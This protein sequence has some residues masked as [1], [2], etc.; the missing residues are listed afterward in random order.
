M[1]FDLK[2]VGGLSPLPAAASDTRPR[3]EAQDGTKSASQPKSGSQAGVI[4]EIGSAPSSSVGPP[5]DAARVAEIRTA[6]QQGT[7]PL[8]PTKIADAMVAATMMQGSKE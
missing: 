1:S 5:V 8:L 3:S 2:P 6:I 4:V 7:Y